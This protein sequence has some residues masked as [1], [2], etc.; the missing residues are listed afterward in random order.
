[1]PHDI[2]H[3]RSV[4]K[5]NGTTLHLNQALT[6]YLLN[7]FPSVTIPVCVCVCVCVRARS[8]DRLDQPPRLNGNPQSGPRFL[9]G[10]LF[11]YVQVKSIFINTSESSSA[12]M[13]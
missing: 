5:K 12:V 2:Y 6:F 11:E 8:R 9:L 10:A 4:V 3:L 1:M 7:N 13:I